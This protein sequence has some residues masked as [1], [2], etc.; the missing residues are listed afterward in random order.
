MRHVIHALPYPGKN[1]RVAHA[2]DPLIV[3]TAS[4][5]LANGQ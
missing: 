2:A 3:G 5:V 4:D 1:S